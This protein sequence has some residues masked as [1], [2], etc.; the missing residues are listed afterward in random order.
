MMRKRG[1]VGM[2]MLII[3]LGLGV[4]KGTAEIRQGLRYRNIGGYNGYIE[5]LQAYIPANAVV[6][7]QP[8]WFYGFYKQ[9][10]YADRYF[11]WIVRTPHDPVRE[12]LGWSFKEALEQVGVE[13][14]IIDS[15]LYNRMLKSNALNSL[16]SDEV[17]AFLTEQC[18]LIGEVEDELYGFME[19][20][21]KITRIYKVKTSRHWFRLMSDSHERFGW[22]TRLGRVMLLR[23][24]TSL[25]L[26]GDYDIDPHAMSLL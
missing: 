17:I 11:A 20:Q 15:Q 3:L 10:Y 16:P 22:T 6:M 19:G 14:L 21:P 13:Y 8:T 23:R 7:G 9:P 26:G 4:A 2:G 18:L 5:K 25:S 12:S 1:L 24:G